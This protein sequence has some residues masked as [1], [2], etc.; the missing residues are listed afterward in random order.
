M[1]RSHFYYTDRFSG[2]NTNL[3]VLLT[4]FCILIKIC[5]YLI[6]RLSSEA[7]VNT[8]SPTVSLTD[9]DIQENGQKLNQRYG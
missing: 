6:K 8:F 7:A 9:C 3:S 4:D 2:N 1:Q 5:Q